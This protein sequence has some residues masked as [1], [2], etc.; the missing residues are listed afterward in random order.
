MRSCSGCHTNLTACCSD[1]LLV[2]I[3]PGIA[4]PA[5]VGDAVSLRVGRAGGEGAWIHKAQYLQLVI[6]ARLCMKDGTKK[7]E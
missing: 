5:V 1:L 2:F 4:P 7:H 3:E 6:W